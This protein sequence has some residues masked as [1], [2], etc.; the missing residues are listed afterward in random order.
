MDKKMSN[1]TLA[2]PK[3]LKGD[4]KNMADETGMSVNHLIRLAANSLVVNYKK[5]GPFIFADLINPEHRENLKNDNNP[6]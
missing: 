5:S 3:T 1:T 4:L 2:I 6:L